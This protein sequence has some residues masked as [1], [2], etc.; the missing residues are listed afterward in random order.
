VQLDDA[1]LSGER[2]GGNA[3]RGSEDWRAFVIAVETGADGRPSYTVIDP[4]TAFSNAA[5]AQRR[6]RRLQPRSDVYSDG[7][8]VLRALESQ[9]AH[10]VIQANGRAGC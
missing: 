2:N 6:A 9:H 4:V 10:T 8:G 7:S 1:Y 3:G 5:L